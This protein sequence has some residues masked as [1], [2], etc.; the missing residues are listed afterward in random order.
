M[1]GCCSAIAK[2]DAAAAAAGVCVQHATR[3]SLFSDAVSASF[4]RIAE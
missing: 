2:V 1:L 4:A 3:T